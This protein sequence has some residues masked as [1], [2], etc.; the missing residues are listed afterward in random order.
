MSLILTRIQNFR[1]KSNLDKNESRPSRYGAFDAFAL[2]NQMPNS[3]LTDALKAT[4]QRSMGTILETPVVDYDGAVTIGNARTLEIAD[5]E[6]TSHMVQFTFATLAWGFTMVPV[7]YQ[8]NEYNA[9]EDFNKK[10][11]KYLYKLAATLDTSALAA[12]A[13]AKTQVIN[14]GLLYDKTGAIINAKWTERENVLGDLGVIMEAND[15]Y[16]PLDIVSDAGIESIVKNLTK[17]GTY[18]DINKTIEYAD[19]R[20]HYTNRFGADA[21]KYAQGYAIAQG[22]LGLL[23]RFERE[24]VAKTKM[25]DGTEWDVTNLP[26]LNIPV[27]TYYYED[28]GN[29]SAIA[30]AASADM[31]R[32]R[33]EHYGFAVDVCFVTPYN[34]DITTRPNPILAF[35]VSN[36]NASY[37]KPVVVV[38]STTNPVNTKEV[39]A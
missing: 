38:N 8:N 5:S 28:K 17:E 16:D 7:L 39:A 25:A 30:G 18:N 32:V 36:V 11:L 21:T 3:I 29:Y 24:A 1:E 14:N 20:F 31:D 34:S 33:K 6:N 4:A 37:A 15:F 35:N 23:F 19:K 10:F 2:Q 13:A 27:G 22:S 26:L 12:L 9:Q